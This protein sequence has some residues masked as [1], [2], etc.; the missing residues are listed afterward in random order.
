[1]DLQDLTQIA[2]IVSSVAVVVSLIYASV[3]LRHNTRALMATTYNAVT[4]NSLALLSPMTG[5]PE[6]SEFL[7]RAHA[8]PGVLTPAELMRFDAVMLTVFRH[9]DNLY[10]Q[11]RSGTLDREMWEVY[12]RTLTRWL[13]NEA[14]AAWF[15]KNADS[16]SESLRDLVNARM[17]KGVG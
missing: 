11:F 12:E 2:A 7:H 3:Q 8:E 13:A 14:W 15:R 4:A 9:W 5:S 6:F 10:F 16:C 17:P 1:M